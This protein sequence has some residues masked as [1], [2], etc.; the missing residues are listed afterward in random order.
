MGHHSLVYLRGD[1]RPVQGRCGFQK[2]T[3]FHW[4]WLHTAFLFIND[5]AG[6][7]LQDDQTIQAAYCT[8]RDYNQEDIHSRHQHYFLR[9]WNFDDSV[10]SNCSYFRYCELWVPFRNLFRQKARGT[11][12]YPNNWAHSTSPSWFN[13]DAW[14][15]NWT[16]EKVEIL[17][18]S[19]AIQGLENI[20]GFAWPRK[21]R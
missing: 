13:N 4:F 20:I 21:E 19:L 11:R 3:P 9:T 1:L 8:F 5:R 14:G 7:R 18:D 17:A 2:Q 15:I 12:A 10:L 6:F 16:L